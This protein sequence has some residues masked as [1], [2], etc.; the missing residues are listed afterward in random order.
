PA[1]GCSTPGR[2]GACTKG[3]VREAATASPDG[4][5]ISPRLGPWCRGAAV[6]AAGAED[7]GGLFRVQRAP[8]GGMSEESAQRVALPRLRRSH[9]IYPRARPAQIAQK[10]WITRE[11]HGGSPGHGLATS[12]GTRI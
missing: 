8:V 4:A 6:L 12:K 1:F 9:I 7:R 3:S 10:L 11:P 2:T 5:L